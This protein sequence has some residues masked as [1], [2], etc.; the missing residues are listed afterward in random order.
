M[1]G[2]EQRCRGGIS[3]QSAVS[4]TV[5]AIMIVVGVVVVNHILNQKKEEKLYKQ[6]M[7]GYTTA[8]ALEA[9]VLHLHAYL[10]AYPQGKYALQMEDLLRKAEK[11]RGLDLILDCSIAL[12]GGTTPRLVE[13]GSNRG[14][15]I[16]GKQVEGFSTCIAQ[17]S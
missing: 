4:G 7:T 6:S 11:R 9:K 13:G 3:L 15:R 14:L 5:L 1:S 10:D 16:S 2:R 8:K 12:K 17:P